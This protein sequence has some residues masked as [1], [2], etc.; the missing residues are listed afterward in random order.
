MN[1]MLDA[2]VKRAFTGPRG[3]TEEALTTK[4]P[5]KVL[6]MLEI[7]PT[8]KKC[9]DSAEK[10]PLMKIKVPKRINPRRDR[11]PNDR[12]RASKPLFTTICLPC[13]LLTDIS[14]EPRIAVRTGTQAATVNT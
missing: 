9:M 11:E 4:T 7:V 2:D 3:P 14:T 6:R 10:P 13:M 1:K 12:F 8:T 5:P